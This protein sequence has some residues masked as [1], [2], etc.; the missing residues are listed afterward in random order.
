MHLAIKL[1]PVVTSW[2]LLNYIL[3]IILLLVLQWKQGVRVTVLQRTL[4]L[5]CCVSLIVLI[6]DS[7]MVW[8]ILCRQGNG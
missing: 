3:R 1:S 7:D 6:G 4:V 8:A 2:V 5:Q